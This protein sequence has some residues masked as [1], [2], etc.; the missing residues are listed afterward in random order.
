M[1]SD[2]TAITRENNI[3][4]QNMHRKKKTP[5]IK[6][7]STLRPLIIQIEA[8]LRPQEIGLAKNVMRNTMSYRTF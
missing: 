6:S 2:D 5:I 8:T 7:Q 3:T 1:R 4:Q